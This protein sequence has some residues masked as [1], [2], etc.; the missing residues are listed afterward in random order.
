MPEPRPCLFLG[1]SGADTDAVAY[2]MRRA[3]S[4]AARR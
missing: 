1:H 4:R 3:G 2:G